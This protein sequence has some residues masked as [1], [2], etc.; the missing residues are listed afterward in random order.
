M[1]FAPGNIVRAREREWVVLPDSSEE[2]LLI[3]P[4]GGTDD[5]VTGILPSLEM[6]ESA[7]FP[8]PDHTK[9]GDSRSGR[10]LRDAVRLSLRAVL[11]RFVVL[12]V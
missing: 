10:F 11:A 1:S 9:P 4:L 7:S 12:D 6:V 5:E 3:K 2:L 8:P